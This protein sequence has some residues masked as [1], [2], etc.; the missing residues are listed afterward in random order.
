M[1]NIRTRVKNETHDQI[2]VIA[3]EE[4]ISLAKTIDVLLASAVRGYFEAKKGGTTMRFEGFEKARM[5]ESLHKTSFSIGHFNQNL[6]TPNVDKENEIIKSEITFCQNADCPR[7]MK[8]LRSL[9]IKG[10][11]GLLYCSDYCR[12]FVDKTAII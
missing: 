8:I 2:A 6:H 3:K 7:R 10:K 11:G 9:G 1:I 5:S 4:E 12:D